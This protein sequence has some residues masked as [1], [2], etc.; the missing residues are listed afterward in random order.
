MPAPVNYSCMIRKGRL[1]YLLLVYGLLWSCSQSERVPQ[2]DQELVAIWDRETVSFV[3]YNCDINLSKDLAIGSNRPPVRLANKV[4]TSPIVYI[5]DRFALRS[6]LIRK[7][8]TENLL[9]SEVHVFEVIGRGAYAGSVRVAE[10]KFYNFSVQGETFI[11]DGTQV[12][13]VNENLF[14]P[15][16]DWEKVC[17]TQF[18]SIPLELIIFSKYSPDNSWEITQVSMHD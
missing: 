8:H 10:D 3:E 4:Y 9:K 18:A 6:K 1:L 2:N 7:M 15:L 12:D 13:S 5:K 16:K 11:F 17:F 14:T